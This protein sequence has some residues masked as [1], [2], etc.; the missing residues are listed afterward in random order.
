MLFKNHF[1]Y[2][3]VTV[4]ATVTLPVTVAVTMTVN[5][6]VKVTVTLNFVNKLYFIIFLIPDHGHVQGHGHVW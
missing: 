6:I 2:V 3:T 1:L 4:N 5:V